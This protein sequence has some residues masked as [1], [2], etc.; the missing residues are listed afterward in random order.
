M[1]AGPVSER[2]NGEVPQRNLRFLDLSSISS[3]A[4]FAGCGFID[5]IGLFQSW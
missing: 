2:S 1:R 3:K 5:L 4:L